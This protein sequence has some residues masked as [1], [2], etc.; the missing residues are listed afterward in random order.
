M[1]LSK[2]ESNEA[3]ADAMD[4]MRGTSRYATDTFLEAVAASEVLEATLL[5]RYVKGDQVEAVVQ[6]G[7]GADRLNGR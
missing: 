2:G 5:L 6:I 7:M 4:G 3:M 1:A